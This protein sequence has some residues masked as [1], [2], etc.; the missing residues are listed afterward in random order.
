MSNSLKL[1]LQELR[2]DVNRAVFN[3]GFVLSVIGIFLMYAIAV[4]Y[5]QSI[6]IS[7]TNALYY[8][9]LAHN[10]NS[11]ESVT[12]VICAIP[13]ATSFCT[14]WKYQ[15][16]RPN[17]MRAGLK[18]Y[19]RT[20][21]FTVALTSFFAMALGLML[22]LL[23]LCIQFPLYVSENANTLFAYNQYVMDGK[24]LEYILSV[25]IMISIGSAFWSVFAIYISTYFT[26]VLVT[27]CTPIIGYYVLANASSVLK[28][29][30]YLNLRILREN[31]LYL[32]N[33]LLSLLLSV[34]V[35]ILLIV[36]IGCLFTRNVRRRLSNG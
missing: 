29:P 21:V 2:V 4:I 5:E 34:G 27:L 30:P 18:C 20:R 17:I 9:S 26:N 14:D 36:V 3:V 31:G 35:H 6:G 23:C 10:I 13:F 15:F 32:E 7:T 24:L 28:L 22:I 1:Y 25:I 12:L 11:L 33:P 8:F 16:I 19:C